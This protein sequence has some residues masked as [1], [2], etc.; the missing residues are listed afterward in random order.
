M[1][2]MASARRGMKKQARDASRRKSSLT[3]DLNSPPSAPAVRH[4]EGTSAMAEAATAEMTALPIDIE[5]IEDDDVQ[6]LSSPRAFTQVRDQLRPRPVMVVLDEDSELSTGT[7]VI[8]VDDHLSRVPLNNFRRR[9]RLSPN[10]AVINCEAYVNVEDDHVA[11][12][13]NAAN[14]R[15]VQEIVVPKEPVFSCP[16]CMSSLVDPCSTICG[17]IFCQTC[18]KQAL[19]SQ[20]KC[21]TCRRKLTANNFHRVFLPTST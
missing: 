4:A 16:I 1:S 11:K 7:S 18:I 9:Q 21:P 8:N 14:H 15:T 17:H 6:L 20:K 5:A 12:R 3:I 2:S 19:Q 13:R 10:R